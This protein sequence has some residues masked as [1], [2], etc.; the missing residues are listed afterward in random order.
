[1]ESGELKLALR[2]R[3]RIFAILKCKSGVSIMLVLGIMLMLLAIA[4]SV[5]GA[6]SAN[7]GYNIRQNETNRIRLLE[8]SIQRNIQHSLENGDMGHELINGVFLRYAEDPA[9]PPE[10]IDL[11]MD[12]GTDPYDAPR[13][14]T[15]TITLSFLDAL[16]GESTLKINI[17]PPIAGAPEIPSIDGSVMIPAVPRVPGTATI[18][19]EMTVTVEI[20][21][22][23][24][25]RTVTTVATYEYRGGVMTDRVSA[26]AA[27]YTGAD[28]YPPMLFATAGAFPAEDGFDGL[29]KWS[30]VSY[31]T[32]E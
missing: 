5:M 21:A 25:V 26:A 30:L 3:N 4:A 29:G 13:G 6:A 15:Y 19:A 24:G 10:D 20:T 17:T 32:I 28:Y 16:T 1:V 12:I 14:L 8:Q 23:N 9:E 7:V 27:S 31:E 18:D 22:A 2:V 11:L